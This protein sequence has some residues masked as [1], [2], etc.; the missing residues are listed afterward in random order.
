M[1]TKLNSY[2]EYCEREFRDFTRAIENG[3]DDITNARNCG[4]Q[5]CLGVADFLQIVEDVP[6]DDI[7]KIYEEYRTKFY[8]IKKGK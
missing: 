7:N 5:R 8:E 3:W 6:F 4:L 2:K 1:G